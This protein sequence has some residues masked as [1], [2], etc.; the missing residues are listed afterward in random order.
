[1]IRNKNIDLPKTAHNKSKYLEY[2]KGEYNLF[3]IKADRMPI[4]I[5]VKSNASFT[6][7]QLQ[8]QK[9]D[10]IYLFSDGYADQFGGKYDRKYTPKNFKNLLLDICSQKMIEQQKII[11]QTHLEWKANRKQLDDIII[12]GVEV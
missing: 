10:K 2:N 7:Y 12:I 9:N 1:M 5:Y 6:N 8:L 4:G 11:D 3:E